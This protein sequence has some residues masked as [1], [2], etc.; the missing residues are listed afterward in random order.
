LTPVIVAGT[1]RPQGEAKDRLLELHYILERLHDVYTAEGAD[2][3]ITAATA[4]WAARSRPTCS[5][6]AS[7]SECS[8]PLSV[9]AQGRCRGGARGRSNGPRTTDAGAFR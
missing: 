1:H 2:I 3:W 5:L 4:T 6:R 8:L 9:S 7:L